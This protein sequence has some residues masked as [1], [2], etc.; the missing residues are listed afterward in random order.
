MLFAI[1][2]RDRDGAQEARAA[3]RP[4][5]LDFIDRH[6]DA[7]VLAGPMLDGQGNPIGSLLVID[8]VGQ[9]AAQAFAN[10]DPYAAAGVFAEVEIRP[11]RLVV[12]DGARV[13]A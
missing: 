13:G 6:R 9:G 8:A 4:A 2:C 7:V 3:N 12:K 11:F 10:A 1:I 5:H